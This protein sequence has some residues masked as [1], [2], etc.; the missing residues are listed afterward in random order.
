M[1]GFWVVLLV[2]SDCDVFVRYDFLTKSGGEHSLF[3]EFYVKVIS[4]W[5]IWTFIKFGLK[6]SLSSVLKHLKL[7]S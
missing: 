3:Y 1:K 4:S 5:L 6:F 2:Y 7:K